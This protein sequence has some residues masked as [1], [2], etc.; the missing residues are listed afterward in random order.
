M[1]AIFCPGLYCMHA[2]VLSWQADC[3]IVIKLV[4]MMMLADG[5]CFQAKLMFFYTHLCF[6]WIV[7]FF[8]FF[9]L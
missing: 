4:F 8:T 9:W 6:L 3:G 7:G 2:V 1:A 5:V